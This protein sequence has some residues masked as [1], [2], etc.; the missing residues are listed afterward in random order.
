M[1]LLKYVELVNESTVVIIPAQGGCS[2]G[3]QQVEWIASQMSWDDLADVRV[4][5]G[6]DDAYDG[7]QSRDDDADNQEMNDLGFHMGVGWTVNGTIR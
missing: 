2:T 7:V 5:F 3:N 6:N 1:F 4:Q